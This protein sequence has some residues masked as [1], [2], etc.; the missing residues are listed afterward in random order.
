M[1]RFYPHNG[2]A[3]V[4]AIKSFTR[5]LLYYNNRTTMRRKKSVTACNE[6]AVISM[7]CGVLEMKN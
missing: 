3:A 4:N 6:N 5:R 7:V 1:G 2:T